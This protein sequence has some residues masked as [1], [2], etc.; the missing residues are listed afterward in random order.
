M[1]TGYFLFKRA[2]TNTRLSSPRDACYDES[3]RD[4]CRERVTVSACGRTGVCSRVQRNMI[5]VQ[6][7]RELGAGAG[8]GVAGARWRRWSNTLLPCIPIIYSVLVTA[9]HTENRW[10]TV[11]TFKA[12]DRHEHGHLDRCTPSGAALA[13]RAE[14]T[15]RAHA[16]P[17]PPI[18]CFTCALPPITRSRSLDYL[19]KEPSVGLTRGQRVGPASWA[20]RSPP[21]QSFSD[22]HS[23]LAQVI[24]GVVNCPAV[25]TPLCMRQKDC[26]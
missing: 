8:A 1:N 9:T 3:T 22:R 2:H 6:R 5:H 20:P 14:R 18:R 21:P 15:D 11:R 13:E 16:P 23:A 19:W 26:R 4:L 24:G 12:A 17:P 7:G 10:R 25:D